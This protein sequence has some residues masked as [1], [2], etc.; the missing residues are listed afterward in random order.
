VDRI[1]RLVRDLVHVARRH[2]LSACPVALNAVVHAVWE[3]LQR[4]CELAGVRVTVQ[5]PEHEVIVLGDETLLRHALHNVVLNAVQAL[6]DHAGER[7]LSIELRQAGEIA[8]IVVEDTGPGIPPEHYAHLSEPFF[9]TK[10][11]G[12]G[13]GLGLSIT[14]G[15]LEEHGGALTLVPS[16][17]G[18]VRV[19]L[20]L[21]VA[22]PSSEATA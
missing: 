17:T 15:I 12:E 6:R 3:M 22:A 10:D 8:R 4:E 11:V 13:S 20:D 18:G 2:G 14:S 1:A 9:T 19:H 5:Q 21:P 7:R 16:A